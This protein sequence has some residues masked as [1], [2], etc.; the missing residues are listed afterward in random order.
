MSLS[1][2][3][4]ALK[5]RELDRFQMFDTA[6]FEV[7][8]REDL[9]RPVGYALH[10]FAWTNDLQGFLRERHLLLRDEVGF[11]PWDK[12]R[13]QAKRDH[14]A[15]LYVLYHQWQVL[16]VAELINWLTP[17]TPVWDL[18]GGL[19]HFFGRRALFAAMPR[20]IPRRQLLANAQADRR[21]ELL[22]LRVQNIYFPRIRGG[23]YLASHDVS[24]P[25]DAAEVT[26]EQQRDFDPA[27][28]AR[29]V[30]TTP[31]ELA[32]T[33]EY[34]AYAGIR[35]DPVEDLFVLMDGIRRFKLDRLKGK[36]RLSLDYY[37][38]ARVLRAWHY[39]LTDEWLPDVDELSDA[40]GGNWKERL[41]GSRRPG[42]DRSALPL[43]LDDYGLYP[44]RVELIGEGDSE[45][46]A[47][48]EILEYRYGLTFARLGILTTDL[49]GAGDVG[50]KA[51]RMLSSLRR[52][53]NYFLIVLDDEGDA[54]EMVEALLRSKVIEGIS[55]QQRQAAIREAL[56]D[57]KAQT[58]ETPEQRTAALKAA[59]KRGSSLDREPGAA[60]EHILWR[61]NLEADNF[62]PAE[63]CAIIN[64]EAARANVADFQITEED[65]AEKLAEPGQ[66]K[67]VA[68]VLVDLAER[69]D[70]PLRIGKPALIRALAR[71]AVDHPDL[72]G[73]ERPILG[74]AEHLV[75]LASADRQVRGR[76][77]ER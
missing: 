25:A 75:R 61:E 13:H 70:P 59:A 55:D 18:K 21:R 39:E 12:L 41:Y 56:D 16:S 50:E 4:S 23:R 44:Y 31:E 27:V 10:G 17:S 62:T 33:Y 30:G 5:L 71:H 66:S 37:D 63:L 34:L 38:A 49:G 40:M 29:Q 58:F 46:A 6:A 72:D 42:H 47:L 77:R 26:L 19:E 8:D 32:N 43:L 67:A 57:V 3:R 51:R 54:R 11:I 1:D 68:S 20:P 52:Y 7:L 24:L 73:N 48:E 2:L 14:G 45:L 53:A 60:P 64:A 9:L 28:A 65:L 22:L 36:A 15:E 69:Q 74:L 76:L 35:A